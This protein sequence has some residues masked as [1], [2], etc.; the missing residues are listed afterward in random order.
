[1]CELW[2]ADS[3]KLAGPWSM[4]IEKVG[5]PVK[6]MGVGE[7]IKSLYVIMFKTL[8]IVDEFIIQILENYTF[9]LC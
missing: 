9:R 4:T 8:Q 5:D 7:P 1:M 2:D 6:Y 3:A